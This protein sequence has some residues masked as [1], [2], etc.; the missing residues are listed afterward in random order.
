MTP[1][2]T[3]RGPRP[4]RAPLLIGSAVAAVCLGAGVASAQIPDVTEPATEEQAVTGPADSAAP[5]ASSGEP[6]DETT[7]TDE[8]AQDGSEDEETTES[9]GG[10]LSLLLEDA[11]PRKIYFIGVRNA[12]F[13]FK[14]GGAQR[15]T[16]LIEVMKLK[17]GPDA[18]IRRY[19][20]EDHPKRETGKVEW[21]G[22]RGNGKRLKRGKFYFR[23]REAGGS[24]LK[25]G[26]AK[27]QRNLRMYE[28]K[29]PVRGPHQYW[30][31]WGAGR[32]H[33]GQDIGAACG[34][35]MIASEPGKV[36]YKGY[37]G[38]GWGY[39]VVINV[40]RS[41]YAALY[42]HLQGQATVRSGSQAKTG[43]R[44]GKVGESGNA[45]GCHLHFEYWKNKWPNGYATPLATKRLKRWD[46]WS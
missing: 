8:T 29:F 25:R 2:D 5:D 10:R 23:V 13:R 17:D 30:D 35:P 37:D 32:G 46:K 41:N 39:Y 14:F 4:G 1:I 33:R 34:T 36:V 45:V 21:N 19:R 40:K 27:G 12:K 7:E 15:A 26:D 9:K 20:R 22:R 31:G 6:T 42:S 16:L 28:A 44:I 3:V 38:G 24:R 43:E 18:M 11:S